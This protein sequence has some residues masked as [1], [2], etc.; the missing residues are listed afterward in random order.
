M[1]YYGQTGDQSLA[2]AGCSGTFLLRVFMA[3]SITEE[4]V[5]IYKYAS[6]FP[7]KDSETVLLSLTARWD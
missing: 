6:V 7:A 4:R 5:H 2:P 3:L 1:T